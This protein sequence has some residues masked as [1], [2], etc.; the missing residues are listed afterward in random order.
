MT[1]DDTGG[2]TIQTNGTT[3]YGQHYGT[4]DIVISGESYVLDLRHVFSGA[5]QDTFKETLEDLDTAHRELGCTEILLRIVS[6]SK[7][8]MSDQH[9]TEK[10]FN[11]ML[12]E[13]HADILPEVFPG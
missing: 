12:S 1:S 6:K 3:K 4:Y 8:T 11:Q 10:L 2:F 9:A 7:N 13:Y 5:A